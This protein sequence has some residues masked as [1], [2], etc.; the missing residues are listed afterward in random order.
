M[1]RKIL[2]VVLLLVTVVAVFVLSGCSCLYAGSTYMKNKNTPYEFEGNISEINLDS[3]PQ[4]RK[5]I[6]DMVNG[7]K[8][9]GEYAGLYRLADEKKF[10]FDESVFKISE[11]DSL[12]GIVVRGEL[13]DRLISVDKVKHL[14]IKANRLHPVGAFFVGLGVDAILCVAYFWAVTTA[15]V[16]AGY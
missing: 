9:E 8:I 13:G 15:W 16:A 10:E 7:D 11:A 12:A 2:S 5:I 4:G 3:L 1:E 14:K 6:V